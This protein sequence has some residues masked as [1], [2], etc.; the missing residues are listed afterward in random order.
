MNRHISKIITAMRFPTCVMVVFAHSTLSVNMEGINSS[1]G[2]VI[3]PI[4]IDND[5]YARKTSINYRFLNNTTTDAVGLL[6]IDG[7]GNFYLDYEDK[8]SF[9]DSGL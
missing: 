9:F 4:Y 6:E 1:V 7:S 3:S 2:S 5:G 8:T